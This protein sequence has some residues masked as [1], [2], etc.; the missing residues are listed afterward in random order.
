MEKYCLPLLEEKYMYTYPL[1]YVDAFLVRVRPIR[2]PPRTRTF[3]SRARGRAEA[4]GK[5]IEDR[6]KVGSRVTHGT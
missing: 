4:R 2:F 5:T 1:F 6:G 3:V